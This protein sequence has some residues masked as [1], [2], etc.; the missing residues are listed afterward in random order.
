MFYR[1]D[2]PTSSVKARKTNKPPKMDG[3]IR[4]YGISKQTDNE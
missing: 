4:F 2:D 3:W 1:S